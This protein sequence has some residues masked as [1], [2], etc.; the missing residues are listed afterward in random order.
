M[1]DINSGIKCFSYKYGIYQMKTKQLY[2]CE[3]LKY[4]IDN[5]FGLIKQCDI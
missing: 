3:N 2:R 4:Q 1:I 5:S